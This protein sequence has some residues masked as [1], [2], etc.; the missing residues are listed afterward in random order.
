MLLVFKKKKKSFMQK[1]NTD[2]WLR[3]RNTVVQ[4]K[5]KKK[6]ELSVYDSQSVPK[7]RLLRFFLKR[8]KQGAGRGSQWIQ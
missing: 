3:M 5:K 2:V 4:K 6:K 8:K 7:S 1:S